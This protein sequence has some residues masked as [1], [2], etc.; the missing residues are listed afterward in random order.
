LWVSGVKVSSKAHYGLRA[1]TELARAYGRGPLAL[2]EVARAEQLSQGYLEQLIATLR[3]AGLVE[4]TRGAAG[5]YRLSRHPNEI[6]VGQI[7]RALEGPIAPVE[8]AEPTYVPGSCDREPA[9]ASRPLWQRVQISIEQVLD[10]TTL[11]DLYLA[12]H[13]AF[14][15]LD[16]IERS[17]RKALCTTT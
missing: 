16:Q 1:M 13:S 10:S 9:C 8:C 7:Y 17:S 14:I 2:S 12:P 4:G 6:T 15:G 5:G 3:R 11:A